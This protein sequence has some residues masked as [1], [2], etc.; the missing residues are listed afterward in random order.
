MGTCQVVENLEETLFQPFVSNFVMTCFTGLSYF[1]DN[2]SQKLCLPLPIYGHNLLIFLH[3]KPK[4][5]FLHM[6][7]QSYLE[8]LP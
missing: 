3:L 8:K 2:L 7:M 4:I 5:K 1:S 6:Q